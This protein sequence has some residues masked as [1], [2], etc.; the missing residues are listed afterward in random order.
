MA[1]GGQ[2]SAFS[3]KTRGSEACRAVRNPAER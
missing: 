3:G 1:I 2:L